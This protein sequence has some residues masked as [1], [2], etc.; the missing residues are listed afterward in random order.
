M[1][2][3]GID[4]GVKGAVALLD[5]GCFLVAIHDIPVVDV[6][7]GRSSRRRIVVPQF[8]DI[9]RALG[10]DHVVLEYV[11]GRPTDV[12]TYAGEMCR[13]AG[14]IE[15]CVGTL[16]IP[17]TMVQPMAW[18]K[19]AGVALAPPSTSAQRKEAS[20]QRALQLWPERAAWFARRLDADR[21]ESVLIARW[22]VLC[23]GLGELAAAAWR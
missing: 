7:V 21:A 20:R 14:I 18:R 17:I 8:A 15:G 23:A 1:L 22:G 9:L 10:A 12:P 3:A 6:R 5:T 19:A 13:A 4:P 11:H 16:G 2:I